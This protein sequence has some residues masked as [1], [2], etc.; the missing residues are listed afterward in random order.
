MLEN[1]WKELDHFEELGHSLGIT[2]AQASSDSSFGGKFL[3][4]DG[5]DVI[6]LT[7]L[8]YMSL[9]DED[10]I[11]Q[12]MINN[13]EAYDIGCPA[14]QMIL[15]PG[16]IEE[17]E[18]TLA[19]WHGLSDAL[20]FSNGYSVNFNMMQGLGLRLKSPHIT[21]YVR[22][23]GIGKSTKD[24]PTVFLVDSDAHYSLIHGVRASTKLNPKA[25]YSYSY[26]TH[27]YGSLERILQNVEDRFGDDC[28]K[29]I[30][31]DTLT[32][33]L[34][35]VIEV[36]KLYDLAVKY[37]TLLYLDEAHAIG[38][39][40]TNRSGVTRERLPN[41]FDTRRV[42]IMGTLTKAVSQLGG[43]VAMGDPGIKSMMSLVC[44]Q[45][46]FS[47]PVLPWMAKTII[48]TV[49]LLSGEWG[50]AAS[51]TLLENSDYLRD[52]LKNAG[53]NTMGSTVHI[54]PVLLGSIT[55]CNYVRKVLVDKGFNAAAFVFPAMP[56]DKSVLRI[57]MCRDIT[58]EELDNLVKAL[59]EV[60]D[61]I[62]S[63][64]RLMEHSK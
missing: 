39:F 50:K 18:N 35:H 25:C 7:R 16:I 21:A 29:V 59:S 41:H 46:L 61:S 37:D 57:S 45:Y 38:V 56:K 58:R 42:I 47:A 22:D 11:K 30:V 4:F 53:F 31:S 64:P 28:I 2:K 36:E 63:I 9:G 10:L 44:P 32:S 51:L 20:V 6:D 54:V 17:L 14:S 13:I 1:L 55:D 3:K 19:N 15:K 26:K 8:D 23:A 27:D 40:G 24:I 52:R 48:Q 60:C 33:G 34:G 49:N 43:Y 5:K 12:W 62:P